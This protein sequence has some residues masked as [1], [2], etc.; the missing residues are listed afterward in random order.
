MPPTTS[1]VLDPTISRALAV[2]YTAFGERAAWPDAV[3]LQRELDSRREDLHV[4]QIMRDLPPELGCLTHD[5]RATLTLRGLAA[6]PEAELLVGHVMRLIGLA[7]KRWREPAEAAVLTSEDMS[8]IGAD[9]TTRQQVAEVLLAEMWITGGGSGD[10]G[11]EWRRSLHENVRHVPDEVGA[12]EY[13]AIKDRLIHGTGASPDAPRPR[14]L[15]APDALY[16]ERAAGRPR[17]LEP[18]ALARLAFKTLSDFAQRSYFA[19]AFEE[20]EWLRAGPDGPIPEPPR[21]PDPERWMTLAL[22]RDDLWSWLRDPGYSLGS[23]W[24]L[25]PACLDDPEEV[26][27]ILELYMRDVVSRPYL[28]EDGVFEGAYDRNGGRADFR[29]AVNEFLSRCDPPM[30]MRSDGQI[31]EAAPPGLSRLGDDPLAGRVAEAGLETL[32]RNA[33]RRFRARDAASADRRGA[34]TQLAGV[35]ETLREDGRLEARLPGYERKRLFEIANQ[36]AIRHQNASQH[37]GYDEPF[38]EWIFYAYLAAIRLALR[39][40]A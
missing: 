31:A 11:G 2:V 36:F 25:H 6:V 14:T 35:L 27:T 3:A 12:R 21:I 1:D 5:G 10:A 20:G 30:E 32:V 13:F 9:E 18:A 19:E 8:A 26:F 15:L 28:D 33:V 29:A 39:V 17:A 22:G 40:T 16:A 38:E 37:S 4:L 23:H 7:G 24:G 34:L